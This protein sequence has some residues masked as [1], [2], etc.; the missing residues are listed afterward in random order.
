MGF[1]NSLKI[2]RD[3]FIHINERWKK[4]EASKKLAFKQK[5]TTNKVVCP[6]KNDRASCNLYFENKDSYC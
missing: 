4:Q 3:F 2:T 5:R 6:F 1:I